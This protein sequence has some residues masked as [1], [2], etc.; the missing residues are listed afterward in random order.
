MEIEFELREEDYINYNLDHANKSP[1]I[2]KSIMIQRL[3]GP[4]VF[5]FAAFLV[6]RYSDI[7]LWY[8]MSLFWITSIVWLVFYPKYAN[9]EMKRRLKKMLKEGSN[10]N[11][12]NRRLLTIT[13]KG[14]RQISS[15]DESFISWENIVSIDESNNY[16]Y[17]YHSSVS[18]NIIPKRV[19]EDEE[20]EKLF[21]NEIYKHIDNKN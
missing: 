6:S 3:F 9:W 1:S 5:I 15:S 14:I 10:K 16:I 8:W 21:L 17:I 12:F 11:L 19:F 7:P 13:D 4:I 20:E 2:R 18:A